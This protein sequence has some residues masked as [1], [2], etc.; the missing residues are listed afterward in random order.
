MNCLYPH[1]SKIKYFCITNFMRALRAR[2][3]GI[4]LYYKH[5]SPTGRRDTLQFILQKSVVF[6]RLL[7]F[8]FFIL[9]PF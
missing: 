5:F 8:L 6:N 7:K 1:L 9:C 2:N 3:Y 4:I